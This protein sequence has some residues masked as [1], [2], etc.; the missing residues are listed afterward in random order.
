VQR[1]PC[2]DS[3]LFR[4]SPKIGAGNH[5]DQQQ[6]YEGASGN[7]V[8]EDLV[9]MLQAMGLETGI[10]LPKLLQVR[11]IIAAAL[12]GEPL[13]GFTPDAGLPLGFAA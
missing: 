2:L 4:Q 9:F 1:A 6:W 12:P 10:D 5:G 13:Y 11:Q 7:I 8:T 3:C